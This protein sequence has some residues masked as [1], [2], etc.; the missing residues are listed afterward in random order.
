MHGA[1]QV[2]SPERSRVQRS[3][4]PSNSYDDGVSSGGSPNVVLI[5]VDQ[6]AAQWLPA[7]GHDVVHAPNLTALAS[8]SV[9]FEAAYCASPLC[10]PSRAALLSG[11]RASAIDVF[12]NAAELRASVPTLAHHLRAAGYSTCLSGKMHFVGPD[13]LHGFDAVSPPT[14]IPRRS[15][16]RPFGRGR[17]RTGGP[18]TT[19][20]RA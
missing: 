11:R 19:R 5:M 4:R 13:Q 16:G 18:G 3:W 20:S 7:Y 9:T 12:D 14:F 17:W 6:L 1:L 10:A 15:T 8:D 2:R